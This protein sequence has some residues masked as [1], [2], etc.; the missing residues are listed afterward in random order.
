MVIYL[1]LLLFILAPPPKLDSQSSD[2]KEN[3]DE[4][5][6]NEGNYSL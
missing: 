2:T 6:E 4:N 5:K 3:S 1:T